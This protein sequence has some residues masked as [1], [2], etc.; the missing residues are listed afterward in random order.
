[1]WVKRALLVLATISGVLAIPGTSFADAYA[2][3]LDSVGPLTTVTLTGGSTLSVPFTAS[4]TGGSGVAQV[5]VIFTNTR[6]T[7]MNQWVVASWYDPSQGHT[8]VSA[9][10]TTDLSH[11]VGSGTWTLQR[12]TIRDLQNN[13]RDYYPS[14]IVTIPDD[15]TNPPNDIDWDQSF[16]V[17]NPD[18]DITEPTLSDMRVFESQVVAGEPVVVLYDA[19]D[20][21]SG[22]SFVVVNYDSPHGTNQQ[23]YNNDPLTAPVGPA[24]WLVPLTAYGRTYTASYIDV[25]D[26]A[27][28]I[29]Q[30]GLSGDPEPG[31]TLDIHSVDFTVTAVAEDSTQPTLDSIS[32]RSGR[33]LHPGDQVA[34]DY[35]VHDD[36]TGV[37]GLQAVWLDTESH[38]MEAYV[39]C[40]LGVG[41]GTV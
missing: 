15:G 35:T 40:D 9:S 32:L 3:T 4:D 27:G 12:V 26:R 24:T 29:R 5:D 20:E 38:Q 7:R 2:P 41:S 10:A 34:L 16:D 25:Y 19:H 28:N 33:S 31:S 18:E 17:D 36:A 14:G 13:Q 8:S 37:V 6:A 39:N 11:W 22:V 30:Y 1:M 23:V 21:N